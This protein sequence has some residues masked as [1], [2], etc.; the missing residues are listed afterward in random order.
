MKKTTTQDS[1]QREGYGGLKLI[2]LF[3][4]QVKNTKHSQASKHRTSSEDKASNRPLFK[5]QLKV[6]Y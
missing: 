1:A 3:K 6:F 4:E 5:P 2:S